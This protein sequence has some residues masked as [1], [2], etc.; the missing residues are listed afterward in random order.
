MADAGAARAAA[1]A[2]FQ[3]RGRPRPGA[4]HDGGFFLVGLV[5]AE[6]IALDGGVV[7]G[8]DHLPDVAGHVVQSPW[9]G[10]VGPDGLQVF[11][12][13]GERPVA[14][15][16]E[17]GLIRR[18]LAAPGI[19][20]IGASGAGGEFELGGRGEA[21]DAAFAGATPGQVLFDVIAVDENDGVIIEAARGLAV[22]PMRRRRVPR[23]G[24]ES[25]V[26]SVGHRR[27]GDF[28]VQDIAIAADGDELFGGQGGE[29]EQRKAAQQAHGLAPDEFPGQSYSNG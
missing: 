23:G 24:D 21:V 11:A 27:V 22:L 28:E 17:I 14:A 3:I 8:A 15:G 26:F 25:G 16:V 1:H 18:R 12:P 6:D 2:D 19:E 13:G 29:T 9:I 7:I 20:G 10:R 5:E 4:A